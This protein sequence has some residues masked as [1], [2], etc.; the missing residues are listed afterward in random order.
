MVFPTF[1]LL[2]LLIGASCVVWNG[3]VQRMARRQPLLDWNDEP[4]ARWY[5]ATEL[6]VVFVAWLWIV[7]HITQH[8]SAK[9]DQP[10]ADIGVDSVAFNAAVLFGLT[11]ILPGVLTLNG[12]PG[13]DYGI[14]FSNLKRQIWVGVLGFFACVLPMA[15]SMLVTFPLRDAERQHSLLK[16]IS[17]SPDPIT[18]LVVGMT[19]AVVAPLFEEL[20]FRVILQGWMTTLFPS[21]V[22]IVSVAFV[23]SLVHGW[24]DGL[25][26]LPLALI[27][28]FVFHRRH[29]YLAVVVIH[30][31][32]N[33]TMLLL[34]LMAVPANP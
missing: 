24:R 15:L 12:R 8:L 27:L 6:A 22:A 34:H 28:G 21:P 9:N 2:A 4:R 10:P 19:A 30:T 5:S 17:N 7:Y 25:A 13:S 26:L 32:F 18:I 33:A 14:S 11:I 3:L 23:F 29:S 16:L 1:C 20:L 31:L